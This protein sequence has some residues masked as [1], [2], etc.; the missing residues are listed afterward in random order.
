MRSESQIILLKEHWLYPDKLT[1]LSQL[2]PN[3]SGFVLSFMCLDN[4]LLTDRPYGRVGIL[5]QKY[6]SQSSNIV[7]YDDSRII[8]IIGLEL[9]CNNAIFLFLIVF[10]Y[11]EKSTYCCRMRRLSVRL[12]VHLSV[13]RLW[14]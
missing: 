8:I 5:W 1:L 7:K 6:F 14:I 11:F 2:H 3:F 4:T 10:S 13:C 12:P 9:K